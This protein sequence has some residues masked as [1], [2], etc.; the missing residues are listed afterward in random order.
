[1]TVLRWLWRSGV[2]GNFLAGL[3]LLLPLILT[4][5]ILSWVGSVVVAWFGPGSPI[6]NALRELGLLFAAESVALVVGWCIVLGGIWLVGATAITLGKERL[7]TWTTQLMNRL[8]VVGSIYGSAAQVIQLLQ[9]DKPAELQKAV[10]VFCYFGDRSGAGVLGLQVSD[11]IFRL[12]GRPCILVYVPTSPVPMSGAIVLVPRECVYP[13]DMGVDA[14]MQL[15]L[16]IGVLAEAVVPARYRL[17]A[18]EL[19]EKSPT[20]QAEQPAG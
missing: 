18:G 4:V 15:Y 11:Q 10:V 6:G 7:R 20:E 14:L 3:T 9:R 16:S 1:M 5:A 2:V 8:P 12:N 17:S 13:V 19:G